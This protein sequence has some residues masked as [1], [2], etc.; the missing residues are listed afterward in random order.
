MGMYDDEED[1][2]LSP[3]QRLSQFLGGFRRRSRATASRPTTMVDSPTQDPV[4]EETAAEEQAA[5][6]HTL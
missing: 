4:L 6:Q 5:E 1:V 2:R 3:R